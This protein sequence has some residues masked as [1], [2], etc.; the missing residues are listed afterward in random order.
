[1]KKILLLLASIF[2]LA[3]CSFEVREADPEKKDGHSFEWINEN[4][5]K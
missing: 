2:L 5:D 3:G 4:E 1:M